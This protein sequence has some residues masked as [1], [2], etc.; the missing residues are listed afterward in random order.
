MFPNGSVVVEILEN[1]KPEE[2]VLL[3][4]QKISEEGY[5][6]ALDDFIFSTEMYPFVPLADIIKIDFQITS[7][8]EIEKCLNQLT[9]NNVMLLAEKIETYEE[10]NDAIAMGFNLFQGYFFCKPEV[11]KIKEIKTFALNALKIMSE[12]NKEDF[13]FGEIE[14]L[15]ANDV[16][17]SYKLLRYINSAYY[18]RLREFSTIKEAL[19]Y[20]GQI[21][22]RKFLSLIVLTNL[23]SD[24]PG[25]L[26]INSCIRAMFCESI[27]KMDGSSLNK[28]E[29]FML[30]LFSNIDAILD[31]TMENIMNQIPLS[32]NIKQA[33]LDGTGD[34]AD[35][36][37][38]VKYYEKGDWERVSDI[39]TNHHWDQSALPDYYMD[40]CDFGNNLFELI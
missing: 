30:G 23:S 1:I 10:L 35:A 40:A 29:L 34:M 11:I 37:M 12:I 20:L 38:L 18:K 13:D 36:L 3:S 24:K 15:I 22:I 2:D 25:E 6:I 28:D 8:D 21:E 5:K 17:I 26:I 39:S 9:G 32:K 7:K 27:G 16:S 4:C 33:L 31:Q 19:V 14:K